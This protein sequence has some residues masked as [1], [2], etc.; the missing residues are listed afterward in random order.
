MQR[1]LEN[2]GVT[3]PFFP[4][5]AGGDR[6]ISTRRPLDKSAHSHRMLFNLHVYP[7]PRCTEK[8]GGYPPNFPVCFASCLHVLC[9][10]FWKITQG[11]PAL[12]QKGEVSTKLCKDLS[13]YRTRCCFAPGRHTFC[14]FAVASHPPFL[15]NGV[16]PCVIFQKTMQEK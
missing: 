3:P 10:I 6:N 8:M 13:I 14:H 4:Y 1:K 9:I 11:N 2:W 7:H 5:T 16:F 12:H 15:C